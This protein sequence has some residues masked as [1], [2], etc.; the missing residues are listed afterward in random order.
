MLLISNL[1]ISYK[2][3]NVPSLKDFSLNLSN[4]SLIVVS[5]NS[6]SG[7]STLAKSL[8]NLLPKGVRKT[9]KI[10]IDNIDITNLSH[11]DIFST[12]GFLPQFPM[13]YILNLLV[14]DE[15]AFPLENLGFSKQEIDKKINNVMK[16]LKIQHLKNKIITELSSGELQKVS[17]AT[18]IVSEP[19]I[20]ILDEPFAR[21]D[22]N[23]ELNLIE[24]IRELKN[25][26]LIIILEHHLDYILEIADWL[27]ILDKGLT[28]AQGVPNEIIENLG[29][30]KPEISQIIIPPIETN[31]I[32]F[33]NILID[34]KKYLDLRG[35]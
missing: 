23:S 19:K 16:K 32:S 29:Q 7:K 3:N 30:N 26:S 11:N 20:L 12:I 31:Y 27:V 33:T 24:I 4:N 17:L 6:G 15:I 35:N 9:G 34:L 21:M 18:A 25:N 5:G 13:D 14:Y 22:P 2:H 8:I 10:A 28:V 1:T